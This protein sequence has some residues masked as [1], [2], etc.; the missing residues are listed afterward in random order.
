MKLYLIRHGQT[1]WNQEMRW[2]GW[3]DKSLNEKGL[4]EAEKLAN[5]L[6]EKNIGVIYTSPLKRAF[7]T[8]SEIRKFHPNAEFIQDSLLKEINFGI[9]EGHTIEEI[10]E[11]FPQEW[12]AR[13]NDKFNFKAPNGESM[14]ELD[15]R[16]KEFI[17]KILAEKRDLAVITHG[18]FLRQILV[19]LLNKDYEE[20]RKLFF[21]NTS[22]SVFEIDGN[23]V[24]I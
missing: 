12:A 18:M 22:L 17:K 14:N 4:Q 9:F 20:I 6:K 10:K 2:Q 24:R 5:R 7:Q 19:N 1:D 13:E 8:A 16:A 21:H 23:T 11:K 3:V 15:S